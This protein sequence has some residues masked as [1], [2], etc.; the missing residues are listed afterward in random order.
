MVNYANTCFVVMPF[1]SKK[2]GRRTIDFDSI[3]D[4]VFLPAIS[5]VAVPEGGSLEPRRTDR[6]FFTG[7]IT[8]EMFRYLE[9][10]RFVLADITGLNANVFYE[11]GVRHHA[12]Q[13]G[14]AIF[15]QVDVN[16]PFDISH[17][18]AFPY[19]YRPESSAEESR[20]LITRVLSESLKED[21]TD[22]LI[23]LAIAHREQRPRPE[24]EQL[25]QEGEN[26]LRRQ[27]PAKAIGFL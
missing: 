10:S 8:V 7:D 23:R 16:L 18:K 12:R 27:D 22:N 19:E 21:R 1:G 24:L 11:L 13:S 9:Y 6:D 2:L 17:I 14:T 4:S 26:A 15:R 25:R 20:Q 5:R 3:Y